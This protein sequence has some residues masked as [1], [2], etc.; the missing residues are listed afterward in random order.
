MS[1]WNLYNL[2]FHGKLL[3]LL[4][5]ISTLPLTSEGWQDRNVNLI[6]NGKPER[7][8]CFESHPEFVIAKACLNSE[9]QRKQQKRYC[10][11]YDSVRVT[12]V[13]ENFGFGIYIPPYEEEV[14]AHQINKP[15]NQTI[16]NHVMLARKNRLAVC[17]LH[18]YTFNKNNC[19]GQVG[20]DLRLASTP[21][22]GASSKDVILDMEI[23]KAERLFQIV[24]KAKS[25]S[26]KI[27]R[28]VTVTKPGKATIKRIHPSEDVNEVK[29]RKHS[30]FYL[31]DAVE[32]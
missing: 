23:P 8:L 12:E 25:S 21:S 30:M 26:S 1:D 9:I 14:C 28:L 10:H 3:L 5:V 27:T 17:S 7:R 16:V 22:S 13:G 24:P 15:R 20:F 4:V 2:I 19:N 31:I 29:L 32:H 11:T 18:D 6:F